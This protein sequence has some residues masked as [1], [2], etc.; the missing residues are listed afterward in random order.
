MK[1]TIAYLVNTFLRKSEGFI[2]DQ[3]VSIKN[4]QV[5]VLAREYVNKDLFPYDKVNSISDSFCGIS[6]L[7]NI[8]SYTLFQDCRY[9]FDIIRQKNIKLIHAHFGPNGI[10][11]LKLKEKCKVP[12]IVTFWGHDIT[13]LPKLTLYPPAWFHYWKDFEELKKAGDLFLAV[14]NFIADMLISKGFKKEKVK[15][16]Y[17]GVRILDKELPLNKKYEEK[18]I[19]NVGRLVEKK[20]TEYLIKA[21]NILIRKHNNV[22][23]YICGDGPLKNKLID[24]TKQLRLEKYVKFLGWMKR[25]E[26]FKLMQQAYIF[27]L[28]SVTAKSGD[29]EG[30]PTVILEA[31]MFSLPVVATIHSGIP[32]AVISGE[33]GFLVPEKDVRSLAEKIDILLSDSHLADRMGRK[34]REL[35]EEK[36]NLG[37]QIEKLEQIYREFL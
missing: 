37:K 15:V 24:L 11:G 29:T 4:F 36:F 6:K 1:Q 20:G 21:M 12:L 35:V 30:L 23:L 17:S 13:R 22:Y 5:E 28:P 9:F 16:V 19:L 33:T 25:E 27:V 8:Y 3:V 18:I 32:E 7:Y 26:I 31:M 14:S 34:G 2:Y 10:Y